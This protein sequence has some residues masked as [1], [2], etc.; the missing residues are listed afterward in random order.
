VTIA[1]DTFNGFTDYTVQGYTPNAAVPLTGTE[2]SS[3]GVMTP[4]GLNATNFQ[5]ATGY[6][7]Y[8][9][10]SNRVIAIAVDEQQ[11]GLLWLEATGVSR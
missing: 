1:S 8:P 10:D 6:G 4:T 2:N 3:T 5:M 7:Y 11:L 9:V